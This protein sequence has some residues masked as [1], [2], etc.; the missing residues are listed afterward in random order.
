MNTA[1]RLELEGNEESFKQKLSEIEELKKW[2]EGVTRALW[3][4]FG[5]LATVIIRMLIMHSEQ[6]G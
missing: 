2:K 4:I 5:I 1:Y 3:I 6:G